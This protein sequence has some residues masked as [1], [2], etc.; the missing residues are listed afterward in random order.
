MQN[1]R[2]LSF[3]I[4]NAVTRSVVHFF[5]SSAN[6][7]APYAAECSLTLFGRDTTRKS[8]VLEGARFGQP[9]GVRLDDA[10]PQLQEGTSGFFGLEFSI[11]SNQPRTDIQT[12][13]CIIELSSRGHSCRFRPLQLIVPEDVQGRAITPEPHE[14]GPALGMKDAFN[15]TSLVFVNGSESAYNPK[16]AVRSSSPTEWGKPLSID[17][18]PAH[19][20]IE[21][22]MAEQFAA[23]EDGPRESSWGLVRAGGIWITEPPPL[24]VAVYLMYRDVVTRRPVSVACL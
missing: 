3:C 9:D 10:F 7:A 4:S 14:H 23:A 6:V 8:V 2:W 13:G 20:V 16:V 5:P 12:S 11:S 17:P 24:G 21:V 19:T 15:S 22:D 18:L 1:V